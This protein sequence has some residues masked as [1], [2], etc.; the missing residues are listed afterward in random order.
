MKSSNLCHKRGL[1][2]LSTVD[3]RCHVGKIRYVNVLPL[4]RPSHLSILDIL[5]LCVFRK[6]VEAMF[7]ASSKRWTPRRSLLPT[8]TPT[9]SPAASKTSSMLM[10]LPPT[11]RWTQV[12]SV[13]WLLFCPSKNWFMVFFCCCFVGVF[14]N[15]YALPAQVSC[16]FCS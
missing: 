10:E 3:G 7:Q 14:F 13:I 8:S 15:R 1:N 12:R 6:W 2:S 16:M 5:H 11:G 9:A 4:C